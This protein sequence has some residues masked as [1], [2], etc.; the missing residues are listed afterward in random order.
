MIAVDSR[1][2]WVWLGGGTGELVLDNRSAGDL[3]TSLFLVGGREFGCE[4][5][6]ERLRDEVEVRDRVGDG[7]NNEGELAGE[8]DPN[9][10]DKRRIHL[11]RR[12]VDG[13]E[14]GGGVGLQVDLGA[15]WVSFAPFE[16]PSTDS[17]RTGGV[18]VLKVERRFG[19]L[20]FVLCGSARA[21]PQAA[22]PTVV[23][24]QS[25]QKTCQYSRVS[26]RAEQQQMGR[27]VIGWG[28]LGALGTL[29]K[30]WKQLE[31]KQATQAVGMEAQ[32]GQHSQ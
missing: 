30:H 23:V 28:E 14:V 18:G 27:A 20:S 31:W 15:N 11:S 25:W 12:P 2:L 24:A 22:I 1:R 17:S 13:R 26:S 3:L 8:L 5:V 7:D 32:A 10:C 29:E 16:I 9:D 19:T 4:V 21:N 6:Q